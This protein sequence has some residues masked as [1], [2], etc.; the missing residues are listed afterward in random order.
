MDDLT[1]TEVLLYRLL[2]ETF[3]NDNLAVNMT[4]AALF[5]NDG[6]DKSYD[7]IT[8]AIF[9]DG[10]VTKFALEIDEAS[11]ENIDIKI[12]NKQQRVSEYL[13]AQ[14]VPYYRVC[15]QDLL[16][17]QQPEEFFFLLSEFFNIE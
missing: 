17:H 12:L 10:H 15:E 3:G 9:D 13:E 5:P 7:K 11:K 6:Q 14:K 4:V 2:I 1:C 8:F 16:R